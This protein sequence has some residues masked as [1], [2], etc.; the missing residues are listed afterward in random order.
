MRP[1]YLGFFDELEKL[2][3]GMM[4]MPQD[5]LKSRYYPVSKSPR[6]KPPVMAD[7]YAAAASSMRR[8]FK[9]SPVKPKRYG[10]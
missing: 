2:A 10:K 7:P 1:L 9:N 5:P 3:A 6:P 4:D 8:S